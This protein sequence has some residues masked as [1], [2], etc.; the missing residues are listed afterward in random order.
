M[1]VEIIRK[2]CIS[3]ALFWTNHVDTRLAERDLKRDDIMSVLMTGEIIEQYTDDQPYPS[4]LMLGLT[5]SSRYI[6]VVCGTNDSVL[7]II[8][9]YYPNPEKWSPDFKTRKG[10]V[11]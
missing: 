1:T 7:W 11:K 3:K 4:C 2:L 6:H 9:A 5:L 8:T 10:E